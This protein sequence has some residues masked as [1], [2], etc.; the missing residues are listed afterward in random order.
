MKVYIITNGI[1]G[2]DHVGTD[3]SAVRKW[4][5]S[6]RLS[7]GAVEVEWRENWGSSE[8][9]YH[10]SSATGRWNSIPTQILNSAELEAES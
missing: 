5:E 2:V 8:R 3:E 1:C 7:E 6:Q 4:A 10:R 9:L